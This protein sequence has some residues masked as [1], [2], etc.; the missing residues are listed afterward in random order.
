MNITSVTR[1]RVF[2]Y[3]RPGFNLKKD[4]EK[5]FYQSMDALV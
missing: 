1:R 3:G 2:V 4:D 5:T